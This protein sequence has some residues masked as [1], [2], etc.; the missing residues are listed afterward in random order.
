MNHHFHPSL[1]FSTAEYRSHPNEDS[2]RGNC[3]AHA[4]FRGEDIVRID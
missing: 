1:P 3:P 4:I 2:I